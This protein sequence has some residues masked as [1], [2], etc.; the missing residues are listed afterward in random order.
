[1][2]EKSK[3]PSLK[4]TRLKTIVVE[5]FK[6]IHKNQSVS[7]YLAALILFLFTNFRYTIRKFKSESMVTP[8]SLTLS[9]QVILFPFKLNV[10]L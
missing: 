2:L 7:K 5:T 9:S 4:I 1:L 3:L 6:I 10:N 8:R